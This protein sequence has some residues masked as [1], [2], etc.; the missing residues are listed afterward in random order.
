[1]FKRRLREI[2]LQEDLDAA[3]H[4]I[5]SYLRRRRA[6]GRPS[7]ASAQKRDCAKQKGGNEKRGVEMKMRIVTSVWLM[8]IAV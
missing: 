2:G 5:H 8:Q 1:M 6:E 4:P 3:T 7:G